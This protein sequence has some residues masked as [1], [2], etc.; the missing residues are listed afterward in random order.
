MLSPYRGCI[1][2]VVIL[3]LTQIKYKPCEFDIRTVFSKGWRFII[4]GM[5][6]I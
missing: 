5:R 2:R 6:G 1:G 4:G 3:F